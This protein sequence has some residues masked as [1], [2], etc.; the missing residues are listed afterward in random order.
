MTLSALVLY[1]DS[2]SDK[3]QKGIVSTLTPGDSSASSSASSSGHTPTK[4]G[5]IQVKSGQIQ[6]VD[7]ENSRS[8]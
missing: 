8:I 5:T 3:V 1:S 2:S 6:N 7:I 4:L